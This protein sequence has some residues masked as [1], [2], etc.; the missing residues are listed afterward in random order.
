V[1]LETVAVAGF[2]SING[3]KLSDCGGFNVLI[4][5]NNSGKSNL[6]LAI[7]AF[8]ACIKGGEPVLLPPPYT[9]PFDHFENKED[10]PITFTLTFKL[11]LAERDALI[12]DIVSEAPQVKNA[13]EGIDPDLR[14]RVSVDIVSKPQAFA[15]LKQMLLCR[16]Q[17]STGDENVVVRTILDVNNKAALELANKARQAQQKERDASYVKEYL[18]STPAMD[19]E[20]WTRVREI[21]SRAMLYRRTVVRPP[22][23]DMRNR[24]EQ[25]LRS[26][27]SQA[28][29]NESARSL[30]A[31]I[32]DEK[33]AILVEPLKNRIESL[34][35]QE[36]AFPSYALNL[37]KSIS[38]LKILYLT[39]RREPIGKR[40]A[41]QLLGLKIKRGGPEKLRT[42]Q[43][44]VSSLLGVEIDAFQA[45]SSFGEE[46]EAELDVDKF[47]VQINGAGIREALRL[48][49]DYEFA[50]PHILLVEEPEIHL[51]PALETSMMRY[52]KRV[53]EESQIFITTH[54]T[55]FLDTA[56]MRNVYLVSK[57]GATR[58]Q[59][60]NM[61]EAEA[62]IPRELGIRLSSLFMFDRLAFVEGPSD[63]DVLREWAST[64]NINLAQVSVGF[65][66]MGGVRNLASYATEQ[67]I[68]F[69][70]KRQVHMWFIIDRDE[71]DDM[72]VQKL[73]ESLGDRARMIV[74]GKRE[75][76]NYLIVPRAIAKFIEVKRDLS[77]IADQPSPSI[78]EISKTI[79]ECAERLKGI[80]IERRVV[81]YVCAPVYP[82]RKR[83]LDV[84]SG[85]NLEDRVTEE[86]TKQ[87][88][89]LETIET[90]IN[91][92]I[93]QQRN[94]I[95]ESWATSKTDI[96]PGDVLLDEVCKTFG[97]RFKKERDSARLARLMN[98][99]EI[100]PDIQNLLS[101]LER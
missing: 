99:N 10:Q 100:P 7:N 40:E 96:V 41:A 56:E 42:I 23:F 30:I 39:E 28:S 98:S 50:Q 81:K 87:R 24:V 84:N 32:Q 73:V 70:S 22:T 59:L 16:P 52:L 76:E 97:L 80:A 54:S 47:I 78:E 35:G 5:K 21:G 72:E 37:L 26:S 9:S 44:T 77:G 91:S 64:L 48:I 92:V 75:L 95:E 93:D 8:F 71:R 65:V 13:V 1:R 88:K 6:L 67:T 2:R 60:I 58:V 66:P 36:E 68:A 15:Y 85:K 62:S 63:E 69:L 12:Q 49:L 51:H 45:E 27:E 25:L 61:A 19:A 29:F 86:L 3:V 14:L 101:E 89:K 38:R 79:D 4:G 83:V 46:P 34:S 33:S 43:Q 90:E 94:D 74:L 20:D 17:T 55:N 53:G 18:E 31:S 57:N 82:D 11:L